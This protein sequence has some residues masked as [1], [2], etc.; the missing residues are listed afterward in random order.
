MKENLIGD[1]MVG[2][3][4]IYKPDREMFQRAVDDEFD[5]LSNKTFMTDDFMMDAL[6]DISAYDGIDNEQKSLTEA[7]SEFFRK[8]DYMMAQVPQWK[9]PVVWRIFLE[10]DMT[11]VHDFLAPC[12]FIKPEVYAHVVDTWDEL[13]E[14]ALE[15]EKRARGFL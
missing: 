15:M 6:R 12:T 14:Y 5:M 11:D 1:T 8:L 2:V 13:H 3:D 4:E 10:Y 9:G 7:S